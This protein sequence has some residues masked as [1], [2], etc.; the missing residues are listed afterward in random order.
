MT[1]SQLGS[2]AAV[3][4]DCDG[5][6]LDSVLLKEQAF[7]SLIAEKI[8]QHLDAAMEYF[9]Q[10]G[11][12][13]RLEKFRWI[14]ANLVGRPLEAADIADLGGRFERTVFD[15]VVQCPFILGAREFLDRFCPAL[16][17][18][19]ISGT[20]QQELRGVLAARGMEGYFRGI[21]GSPQTKTEIGG[22]ILQENGYAPERVWFVGDAT[23]DRD[24]ARNLKVHF[25][26][27]DGPHLTPFLDGD[28][29]VIKDLHGL[30]S[31]ILRNSA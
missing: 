14:W 11:G 29:T 7:R 25:V 12:T 21:Y 23:T 5:V 2:A 20:P 1:D 16:P 18:Y 17:C 8:P 19:V 26:G 31:A 13:S 10:N 15:L 3:L 24:A 6:L 27:I 9:W 30:E 28:E 4:F 22:R